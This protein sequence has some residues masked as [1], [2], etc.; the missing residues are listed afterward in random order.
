MT[1]YYIFK[2]LKYATVRWYKTSS[3]SGAVLTPFQ[4]QTIIGMILGDLYLEKKTEN[5]NAR[6]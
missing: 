2:T 3:L 5:S 6:L 4:T 1:K